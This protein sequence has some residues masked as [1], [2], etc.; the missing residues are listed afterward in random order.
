MAKSGRKPVLSTNVLIKETSISQIMWRKILP[1]ASP[2]EK[3]VVKNT[4]KYLG[5]LI[6]VSRGNY[7]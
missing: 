5:S 6:G 2:N 4:Q 7:C 1:E 3:R